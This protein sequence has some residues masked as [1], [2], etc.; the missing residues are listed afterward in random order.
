VISRYLVILLAFVAAGI[1]AAQGAWVETTG[2]AALGTGLVI[3]KLASTRPA[4]KP[5][6]WLAFLVTALAIGT[7]LIRQYY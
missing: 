5:L 6:A 3:L 4:L 2:L 1:R 7:V